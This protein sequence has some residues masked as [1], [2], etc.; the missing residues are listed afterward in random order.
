MPQHS[1]PPS[2]DLEFLRQENTRLQQDKQRLE[3]QVERLQEEV[4]RLRRELEKALRAAKR[5]AAPFARRAPKEH[6]RKPGRK[7]GSCYGRPHWR[8]VPQEVDETLE[9]PLPPQCPHC[10]GAVE[11]ERVAEQYQTEWPPVRARRVRFRVQVGHCRRCGKRLQG[12]HPQQTS[13]ALGVARSQLGPRAVAGAVF[14]VKGLGLSHEKARAVFAEMA[15]V[16]VSRSGLCQAIARAGRKTEPTYGHLI[17][18]VRGS[19]VVTPDETGWK[20]EGRLWWLW[21]FATPQV[22]VYAIQ[23]GRGFEQAARV[24]GE[25]FAGLLVR[26]GWSVYARFAHAEHQTCLAHL[27]RRCREMLEVASPAA[28]RFPR[29]VQEILQQALAVRDRHAK[30][31]ISRHGMAVARGR[32]LAR[33]QRAWQPRFHCPANERLANHLYRQREALFTFLRRP[34][35]EATNWRAEQAIRPAV[36][37]RKVWG[38]NRT[39]VGAHTQEILAS[40]LRTCWQQKRSPLPVLQDLLCSPQLRVFPLVAGDLSPPPT[41]RPEAPATSLS[42]GSGPRHTLLAA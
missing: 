40:L 11:V 19:P 35:T 39:P 29:L 10:G 27:L 9:A 8:P 22:T 37:N 36:V 32:L 34:G 30:G 12:R 41:V 4:D 16:P 23:S 3:R 26:D 42:A 14:L 17:E 7:A 1:N 5:Q 33:L 25:E 20:V 31:E 21:A 6:P 15:G 2:S 24:L 28:G 38:G 13:D 18:V